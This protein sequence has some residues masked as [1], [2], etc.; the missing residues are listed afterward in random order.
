MSRGAEFMTSIRCSLNGV[1]SKVSC[2]RGNIGNIW[3]QLVSFQVIY[4]GKMV[5]GQVLI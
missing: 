3:L 1:L 5:N 2:E 4:T